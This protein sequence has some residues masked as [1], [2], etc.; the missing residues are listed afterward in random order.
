M[1]KIKFNLYFIGP[2]IIPL[3]GAVSGLIT[4]RLFEQKTLFTHSKILSYASLFFW[5]SAMS[6]FITMISISL[7]IVLCFYKKINIWQCIFDLIIIVPIFFVIS[8]I[9]GGLG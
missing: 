5:V 7:V 3:L 1:K 9:L 6:M 8:A 4:Q 2:L